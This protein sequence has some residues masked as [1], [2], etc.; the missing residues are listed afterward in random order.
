MPDSDGAVWW[1]ANLGELYCVKRVYNWYSVHRFDVLSWSCRANSECTCSGDTC[2]SFSL[3]IFPGK[4]GALPS[5]LPRVS[6]CQYGHTV[7]FISEKGFFDDM[8]LSEVSIIGAPTEKQGEMKW[9]WR[10]HNDPCVRSYDIKNSAYLF[11][12]LSPCKCRPRAP[13]NLF[14]QRNK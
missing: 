8:I 5:N 6:N 7:K 14:V 3:K 1:K 2:Q 13:K 4:D 11:M 12:K 10:A 9:N